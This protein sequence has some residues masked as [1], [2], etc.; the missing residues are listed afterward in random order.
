MAKIH[1]RMMPGI[2]RPAIA[3]IWPTLTGECIVLDVGATIGADA[4]QLVDFAVMG[5]AMSRIINDLDRPTVGLLNIGVEEMKGVE[6]VR[7]AGQMLRDANF[8]DLDYQGFVEGNDIG[9]GIV[10]VVV[11][12]G[13]AGNIA[14][15][16][17]EGVAKF[18]AGLMREALTSSLSAKAGA[19]LAMP[20]LRAMREKIDPNTL[21]GGPLL[22]LN[23]I[24][25]K[26]HGGAN[27]KG[28]ST[29]IRT[30]VELAD[31]DYLAKVGAKLQRLTSVIESPLLAEP[32][33]QE[34]AS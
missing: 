28:F 32:A 34:A 3:A 31:S 1:L 15:K 11:T 33:A 27:A 26:A 23:G 17:A 7:E 19:L 8:P 16:T 2:E 9:K 25:V 20:A 14:L 18:I 24:V 22:G 30:A 13:F 10:D 12:E 6:E 29:A 21:A 5:A 4:H